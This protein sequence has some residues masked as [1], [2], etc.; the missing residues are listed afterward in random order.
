M[1]IKALLRHYS[2]LRLDLL[3]FG[4]LTIQILGNRILK[5]VL[6]LVCN[7]LEHSW[8]TP[9]AHT[10]LRPRLRREAHIVV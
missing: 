5:K 8:T 6:A 7:G 1:S 10:R 4:I 2:L 3:F 9:R